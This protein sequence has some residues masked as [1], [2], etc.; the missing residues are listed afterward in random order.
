[1]NILQVLAD[2]HCTS[3]DHIFGLWHTDSLELDSGLRLDLLNKHLRLACVESDA[4]TAGACTCC[5]STSMDVGLCLLGWLDLD[6]QVHI[7][8][9]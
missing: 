9:V 1:M 5:S 6:D 8:N 2:V 3:L 7:G 4:S